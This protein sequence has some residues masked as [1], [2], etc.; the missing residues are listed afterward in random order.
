MN[1]DRIREL[2]WE[3]TFHSSKL[4]SVLVMLEEVGKFISGR[5]PKSDELARGVCRFL[6]LARVYG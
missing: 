2:L 4:S 6:C 5:T 1:F 3:Q